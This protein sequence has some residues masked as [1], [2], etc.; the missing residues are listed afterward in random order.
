M[1][2][3]WPESSDGPPV[4][5]GA[6]LRDLTARLLTPPDLY[7]RLPGMEHLDLHRRGR[8]VLD[9]GVHRALAVG[10]IRAALPAHTRG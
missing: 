2:E 1:D 5:G 7:E 10:N 3:Q 9:R 8:L 4:T 6:A